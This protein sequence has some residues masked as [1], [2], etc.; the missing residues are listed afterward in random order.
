MNKYVI[1]VIVLAILIA[2]GIIYKNFLVPEEARPQV[3]GKVRE[4]TIVAKK[5]QWRWEPSVIEAEQGEKIILTVVNEDNYDHGIGIDA[6][7]VN[8]RVPASQ[9]IRVEFVATQPGEFPF[10]CSVTCGSGEVDGKVR[11]HLDQTGRLKVR[12]VVKPQN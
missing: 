8:Q 10:I 7:G 5:N 11:G 2:G 6:F 9:T 3:S 12:A 1:I 4:I